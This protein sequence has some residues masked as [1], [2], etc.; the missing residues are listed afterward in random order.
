MQ[1]WKRTTA[2]IAIV[3]VLM[4]AVPVFA[5][6]GKKKIRG[7]SGTNGQLASGVSWVLS[8]DT[9]EDEWQL[10][11]YYLQNNGA[12]GSFSSFSDTPWYK[13]LNTVYD[14]KIP[15]RC[16]EIIIEDHVNGPLEIGDNVI[17]NRYVSGITIPDQI[18]YIGTVDDTDT[19]T[20][21]FTVFSKGSNETA[22]NF[23]YDHFVRFVDEEYSDVAYD[24]RDMKYSDKLIKI[25]Q[26]KNKM[27]TVKVSLRTGYGSPILVERK[28]DDGAWTK[29]DV[30]KGTKAFSQKISKKYK[31]VYYR[32][33]YCYTING[34]D[35]KSDR[36]TK[37]YKVKNP[38]LKNFGML[39]GKKKKMVIV[40]SPFYKKNTKVKWIS[41]KKKV[42]TVS[43]KGVVRS[44]KYG[45]SKIVAKYK[46]KT[47]AK[48]IVYVEKRLRQ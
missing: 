21:M 33:R 7:Y 40:Y 30:K 47:H 12:I 1:K 35:Y 5:S 2:V 43:K 10:N 27:R 37:E 48:C 9:S 39:K 41:T 19:D 18:S 34:K 38:T 36:N 8:Y 16:I 46:G 26:Y 45:K 14:G 3:L 20:S 32:A 31:K 4:L 11:F 42:A 23:A 29:V 28:L 15:D 17:S 13:H 22:L 24:F 25:D 44:R 6:S